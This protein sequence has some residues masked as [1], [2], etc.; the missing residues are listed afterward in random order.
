MTT[1]SA[2][3][4]TSGSPLTLTSYPYFIQGQESGDASGLDPGQTQFS[5]VWA[6]SAYVGGAVPVLTVPG[7]VTTTLKMYAYDLTQADIEADLAI[8]I[9]AFT[10]STY[11][12]TINIDAATYA[13][14]CYC[15][16][17]Q[18][19]AFPIIAVLGLQWPITFDIPRSPYPS[20]GPF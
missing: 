20:S 4:T 1:V 13:W 18:P 5:R 12:L 6:T 11:T 19:A 10:Q 15:A 8:L 3:V 14:T 17:Y 9:A 2:T 16:D 7:V